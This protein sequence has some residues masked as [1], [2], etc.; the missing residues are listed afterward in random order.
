MRSAITQLR[1]AADADDLAALRTAFR[2]WIAADPLGTARDLV[3][4]YYVQ[5]WR[6]IVA[7][8]VAEGRTWT[9]R[10]NS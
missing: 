8:H 5:E 10:P 4:P 6:R 2:L 1:A 9:T 3:V 7:R